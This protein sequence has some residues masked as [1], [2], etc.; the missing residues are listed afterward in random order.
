MRECYGRLLRILRTNLAQHR[1]TVVTGTPGGGKTLFGH[2]AGKQL[3]SEGY[4]VI[5]VYQGWNC[6]HLF[7]PE[8]IPASVGALL[9]KYGVQVPD[10][11]PAWA[12]R[13]TSNSPIALADEAKHLYDGLSSLMTSRVVVIVDPPRMFGKDVFPA[14]PCGS[15]VVASPG[16]TR[17]N[18]SVLADGEGDKIW[19]PLWTE[20]ELQKLLQARLPAGQVLSEEARVLLAGRVKRFGPIPRWVARARPHA[21]MVAAASLTLKD[22]LALLG[23]ADFQAALNPN[24]SSPELSGMLVHVV[25]NNLDFSF[26]H[27]QFASSSVEREVM[28]KMYKHHR[29]E[30]RVMLA[31]SSDLRSFSQLVGDISENAWCVALQSGGTFELHELFATPSARGGH[32]YSNGAKRTVTLP[33]TAGRYSYTQNLTDVRDLMPVGDEQGTFL[34]FDK[35]NVPTVDCVLCFHE[36]TGDAIFGAGSTAQGAFGTAMGTP[37]AATAAT[38]TSSSSST[39][40]A[41]AAAPDATPDAAAAP[42]PLPPPLCAVGGQMTINT[43]HGCN[44]QG[45][46]NAIDAA[47][48]SSQG[49]LVCF[50]Y[51]IV[52]NEER[53]ESFTWTKPT[54]TGATDSRFVK[55]RQWVLVVKKDKLAEFTRA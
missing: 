10:T 44:A 50:H 34:T 54:G 29:Q 51:V 1:H 49:R 6:A 20:E 19:M 12:G 13:F 16:T 26:S 21:V 17:V 15:L 55:V 47:A 39:S 41:A 8:N 14:P 32:T 7:L 28:C 30:L 3:L 35:P 46:A 43:E 33:P 11:R 25:P 27:K 4:V 53:A 36:N 5:Y 52:T 37:P 45:L 40:V 23:G 31:A 38:T 18:L 2:V 24:S 9:G 42:P 22:A 48:R